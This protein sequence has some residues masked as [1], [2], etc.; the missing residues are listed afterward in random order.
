MN[1]IECLS[2]EMKRKNSRLVAGLAPRISELPPIYQAALKIGISKKDIL[3]DFCTKYINA[4]AEHVA[5][6]KLDDKFF[7]DKDCFSIYRE[8]ALYARLSD[9]FV[10]GDLKISG[11]NSKLKAYAYAKALLG[12]KYPP[13]DAVTINPY[14]GINGVNPFIKTA[15]KNGQGVFIETSNKFSCEIQDRM[16]FD[17]IDYAYEL[18]ASWGKLFTTEEERYSPVGAVVGATHPKEAEALRKRMPNTM[19]L[20]SGGTRC[21][22]YFDEEGL[23]AIVSSSRGLMYAYKRDAYKDIAENEGW[24]KATEVAAFDAKEEINQALKRKSK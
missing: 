3:R 1:A 23:G 2:E 11:I 20:V 6:I 7:K 21:S 24:E 5:A 9:L 18:S 22:G 10:I 4:V 12:G 17:P 15:V 13:F 14:L 19:F 16:W 8:I